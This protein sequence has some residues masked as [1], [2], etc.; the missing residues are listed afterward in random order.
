MKNDK[1]D[2]RDKHNKSVGLLWSH[3]QSPTCYLLL[4][5]VMLLQE[6][7]LLI[8]CVQPQ[9][10]NDW[11]QCASSFFLF[12][13]HLTFIVSEY[14]YMRKNPWSIQVWLQLNRAMNILSLLIKSL[15]FFCPATCQWPWCPSTPSDYQSCS[16]SG[17]QWCRW[18]LSEPG[19]VHRHRA[20]SA[21]HHDELSGR[22]AGQRREHRP[23]HP[24]TVPDQQPVYP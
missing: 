15:C 8:E 22:T 18:K 21:V 1:T 12:K 24:E 23:V 3:A 2:W 20:G 10:S 11:M 9:E 17:Q 5:I 6:V 13:E 14:P 19:A 7:S 16:A 4:P